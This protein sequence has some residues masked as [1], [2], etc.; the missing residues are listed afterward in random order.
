M[1]ILYLS[2][3][4]DTAGVGYAMMRAMRRHGPRFGVR[5]IAA[6]GAS[7]RYL[8]YPRD[9]LYR[10]KLQ[11]AS[12]YRWADLVHVGNT[13]HAW[14]WWD[15]GVQAKRLV[16][17]HHGTEYRDGHAQ[18][19]AEARAI[20]AVQ[21]VSTV[22]LLGLEPDVDT[23]V[24]APYALASLQAHRRLQDGPAVVAHAPTNRALKGTAAVVGAV[25]QLADAGLPVVLDLIEGVSNEECLTRKGRADIL[26]DQL[27]LG[28]GSNAVEAWGM[29]LPVV[30]GVSDWQ[31]RQRMLAQWGR[32]PFVEASPE[33]LVD[34][35]R[36]LVL[37]RAAR[38]DGA[39]AG[40]EH[41]LR[42]H[43]E[44]RVV[45]VLTALYA[46]AQPT[47]RLVLQ[48]AG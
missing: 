30:A 7:G 43:D 32:L 48:E 5:Q 1:N 26:V 28:Y 42:Y 14:H 25:A 44:A 12:W 21:V 2:T 41:F 16:L 18:L 8:A 38:E 47:R 23:W 19:A 40:M 4:S 46:A 20:G 34:V 10:D 11:A 29:G 35:L 6:A 33:T 45:P 39:A 27:Q 9:M 31:A 15:R 37:S 3:G 13:L 36:R 24:P 22:D 17:H